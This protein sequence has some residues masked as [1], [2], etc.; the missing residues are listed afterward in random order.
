MRK[1][2]LM[3]M[4]VLFLMPIVSNA[5]RSEF[6]SKNSNG[7]IVS[8]LVLP[9]KAGVTYVIQGEMTDWKEVVLPS[10]EADGMIRYQLVGF[11]KLIKFIY[12]PEG[13]HYDPNWKNLPYFVSPSKGEQYCSMGIVE[14]VDVTPEEFERQATLQYPGRFGGVFARVDTVGGQLRIMNNFSKM[15]QIPVECTITFSGSLDGKTQ[16][17]NHPAQNVSSWGWGY[18]DIPWSGVYDFD[19]SGNKIAGKIRWNYGG[20]T[21]SGEHIGPV[22]FQ[23]DVL[24]EDGQNFFADFR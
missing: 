23:S 11:N 5:Q 14:G 16:W 13:K 6:V 18:L 10:T 24:C 2:I 9:A 4:I 15:A 8:N 7:T 1:S 19:Q 20:K 12:Y 22:G 17:G 3:L 21:A